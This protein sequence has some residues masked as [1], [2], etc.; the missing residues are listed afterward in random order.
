[1]DYTAMSAQPLRRQ[2]W[3]WSPI[4]SSANALSKP[5]EP[6]PG[7]TH[8][9]LRVFHICAE[10][11]TSDPAALQY[12]YNSAK[13]NGSVL[14]IAYNSDFMGA[15]YRNPRI[16]QYRQ[17][18]HRSARGRGFRP[19]YPVEP[20]PGDQVLY[21]RRRRASGHGKHRPCGRVISHGP[22][23]QTKRIY[24]AGSS[25]AFLLHKKPPL[26]HLEHRGGFSI[27]DHC[28]IRQR[29][30]FLEYRL[31]GLGVDLFLG[32]CQEGI[33]L[34]YAQ[35]AASSGANGYGVVLDLLVAYNQHVGDL[36]HLGFTDLVAH[37][38]IAGI[39]SQRSRQHASDRVP[40][41]HTRDD[42]RKRGSPLPVPEPATAGRHRRTARSG[43]R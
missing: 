38:L 43:Y 3:F 41:R 31:Q 29:F 35:V 13:E 23:H 39:Q 20:L 15:H 22:D 21:R 19:L 37:L 14:E 33:G 11:R 10:G 4:S 28:R 6:L 18:H 25:A 36:H 1:M 34:H 40:W 17:C 2:T 16:H 26:C 30:C 27:S 42:A 5:V 24:P 9:Q 8:T 12:L 7:I 32:L